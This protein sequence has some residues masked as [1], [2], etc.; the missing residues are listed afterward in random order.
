MLLDRAVR[1]RR[2]GRAGDA[3]LQAS[4]P[5]L[6]HTLERLLERNGQARVTV[7]GGQL[8]CADAVAA[9]SVL[10]ALALPLTGQGLRSITFEAGSDLSTVR[11]LV[12]TLGGGSG[13]RTGQG[14]D[15]VTML[16]KKEIPYLSHEAALEEL[17]A[18]AVDGDVIAQTAEAVLA[19]MHDGATGEGVD[20]AQPPPDLQASL[21]IEEADKARSLNTDALRVVSEA[22]RHP[23]ATE[24]LSVDEVRRLLQTAVDGLA[25][26]GAHAELAWLAAWLRTLLERLSR[27][28]HPFGVAV[29]AVVERS[30]EDEGLRDQAAPGG[31]SMSDVLATGLGDQ[32]EAVLAE[33]FRDGK[34]K[35]AARSLSAWAARNPSAA[36]QGLIERLRAGQDTVTDQ[37]L[38][39]SLAAAPEL[40]DEQLRA[41][42]RELGGDRPE[43]RVDVM[44]AFAAQRDTSAATQAWEWIAELD[45]PHAPAAVRRRV[46]AALPDVVGDRPAFDYLDALLRSRALF[47]REALVGM[48]IAA[49]RALAAYP[50]EGAR[51]VL[52]RHQ[53]HRVNAVRAA[54]SKALG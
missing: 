25:T 17:I 31:R 6:L 13:D 28:K 39:A 42:L 14:D 3:E 12:D 41:A 48:Q 11:R 33:R 18:G 38:I 4:L 43:L 26:A 9:T 27:A 49:A 21:L 16:W 19:A 45:L 5:P 1:A 37:A 29:R 35:A 2:L 24:H 10:D 51:A 54:V 22:L 7:A 15:T 8:E 34:G 52:R 50:H 47:R 44:V 20:A 36:R 40:C 46:L 30:L 32:A 23:D 53:S